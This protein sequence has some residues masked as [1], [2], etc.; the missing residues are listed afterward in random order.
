MTAT[1]TI[2]VLLLALCVQIAVAAPIPIRNQN[3]NRPDDQFQTDL[4]GRPL[5]IG[6]EY[7]FEP[8]Y[9]EDFSL[10][11]RPDD[12]LV[13]DQHLQIELLYQ[14]SQNITLFAKGKYKYKT[15]LY[16]EDGDEQSKSSFVRGETW[17]QFNN[18]AG[19]GFGT[20][21][22][23]QNFS[24][25]REWWWDADLDSI[26]AYYQVS[27]LLFEYSLAEELV[28]VSTDSDIDP[29]DDR[30]RR[31]LGRIKWEWARKQ[32]LEL[33]LF[34]HD[35][36]SPT[37]KEDMVLPGDK[38]DEVDADLSW[39]GLRSMGRFKQKKLGRFKYWVDT[40]F[41]QG[42]E[43]IIDFD[44]L[45]DKTIVVDEA[46]KYDV[47]GWG[48][49]IGVTWI[50]KLTGEPRFTLS[51]AQGSGDKDRKNGTNRNYQQTGIHD[52][53]GKFGGV[54][55]FKYYGEVLRPELSNI[56]I[57]TLGVGL[58]LLDSSSVEFLYHNYN[59][60]YAADEIRGSKLRIDPDGDSR[61]IGNEV[62][63]VLGLEEWKHLEMELVLG[64]FKAGDA[65]GKNAGDTAKTAIFKLKYNY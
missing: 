21:I 38:E 19:S 61:D 29:E 8:T 50:S 4:F 55:S 26:R 34:K 36:R 31:H 41:V 3:D 51:Y 7:E 1:S 52:N 17:I 18:L 25:K 14:A 16:R 60:V 10:G 9:R 35:D 11:N 53:N 62:D 57:S 63:I 65:F 56:R 5:T 32:R 6:G 22:G 20:R 42:E 64:V 2:S 33:F 37:P 23:R 13:L 44:D 30:V 12:S 40:G 27:D 24:D 48:F 46:D 49:D 43:T 15:D 28:S 39:I 54:D 59:Q 45:D 58:S 47:E